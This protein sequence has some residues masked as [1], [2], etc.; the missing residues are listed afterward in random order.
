MSEPAVLDENTILRTVREWPQRPREQQ[1][2]LAR[3]ILD[4]GLATIDPQTGL[5][6]VI[7]SELR[8]IGAGG[9]KPPTD[10]EIERW[11]MEKYGE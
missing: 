11:R 4:P 1:A 10:E 7:S 3:L 9:K 5:P 6:Y 2:H 8:G